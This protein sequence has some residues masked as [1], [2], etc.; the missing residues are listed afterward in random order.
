[1]SSLSPPRF[2]TSRNVWILSMSKKRCVRSLSEISTFLFMSYKCKTRLSDLTK[3][4]GARSTL[5]GGVL[6]VGLF[7]WEELDYMQGLWTC[8][9]VYLSGWGQRLVTLPFQFF[10]H[11]QLAMDAGYIISSCFRI[12]YFIVVPIIILNEIA[13]YINTSAFKDRLAPYSTSNFTMAK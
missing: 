10:T 1:M 7:V 3:V 12:L 5:V 13:S 2:N 4:G 6:W 11:F 9:S 8:T